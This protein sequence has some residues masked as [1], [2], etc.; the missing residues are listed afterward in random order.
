MIQKHVGKKIKNTK[1]DFDAAGRSRFEAR[2]T[3]NNEQSKGPTL[4][5]HQK[6]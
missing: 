3:R 4:N 2:K 5:H 1:Q 6:Q